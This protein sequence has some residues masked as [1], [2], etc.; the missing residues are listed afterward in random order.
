ML[1]KSSEI[2]GSDVHIYI[3]IKTEEKDD[4]I[5]PNQLYDLQCNDN[6]QQLS[7]KSDSGW[8]YVVTLKAYVES[9][10]EKEE[11]GEETEIMEVKQ[12]GSRIDVRRFYGKKVVECTAAS[13]DEFRLRLMKKFLARDRTA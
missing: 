3:D 9:C 7:D 6:M 1:A 8:K 11:E 13:H 10:S 2:K 4:A 12:C 5:D